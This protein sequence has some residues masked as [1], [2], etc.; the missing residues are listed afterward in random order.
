M[1]K[2]PAVLTLMAVLGLLLAS[3]S[4]GAALPDSTPTVAAEPQAPAP[5]VTLIEPSP[6]PQP[7]R[8]ILVSPQGV[9]E[10]PLQALLS[11]LAAPSGLAL[12]NRA[13]LQAADITPEV[14]LVVM[15]S[16]A[17]NLAELLAAAP[18]TQFIVYSPTDLSP[19][20]NLTVI[21]QR[22]ENQVFM[23]G[24]IS[25]LITPDYR[26]AGLLPTDGP[27]G[28]QLLEA[29]N[30]GG[31][32]F[33]GTCAPGW[34]LGEYYPKTAGLPAAS[35]G[36]AWQAA[37]AD[38]FDNKK[39]DVYFLAPEASRPEITA[40]LQGK[41]QID[42]TVLIVGAQAPLDLLAAQW[43]ASVTFDNLTP[44]RAVWVDA[45]AGKGGASVDAPLSIDH[46]NSNFLGPGRMRLVNDLLEDMKAGRIYTLTLSPE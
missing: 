21:R 26:A 13:D 11:E 35:D 25:V 22:A 39:V 19:A 29:Y 4:P 24:F 30:N 32:Y 1:K 20:T 18:Q 34:P 40:Y 42:R 33:C 14:K 43:A 23:A 27:L 5:Q 41:V 12:E 6:T 16:P 10:E 2:I 31:R 37:A 38:L 44:L 7:A 8:V 36:A 45:A 46:V 28:A 9:A 3:C 17:V 15:L